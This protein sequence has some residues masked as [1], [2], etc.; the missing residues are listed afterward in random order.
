MRAEQLVPEEGGDPEIAVLV[1]EMVR[2]VTLLHFRDPLVLRLVRQMLDAVDE[3]VEAGGHKPG[4][5]CHAAP[6]TPPIR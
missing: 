2:H 6:P 5:K 3:L 4:R 1:V